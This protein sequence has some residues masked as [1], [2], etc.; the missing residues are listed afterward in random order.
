M[1]ETEGGTISFHFAESVLKSHVY[2]YC[3]LNIDLYREEFQLL[4]CIS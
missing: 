1:N 2:K 3:Y 4:F